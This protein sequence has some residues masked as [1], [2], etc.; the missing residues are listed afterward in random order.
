MAHGQITFLKTT[1]TTAVFKTKHPACLLVKSLVFVHLW[2][3]AFYFLFKTVK[4]ICFNNPLPV[5]NQIS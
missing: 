5:S 1:V 3:F 2:L 4:E